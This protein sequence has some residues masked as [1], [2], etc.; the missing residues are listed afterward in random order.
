MEPVAPTD[1]TH[2]GSHHRKLRPAF[3]T[4]RGGTALEVLLPHDAELRLPIIMSAISVDGPNA[5]KHAGLLNCT[6][7]H[8]HAHHW[9][10]QCCCTPPARGASTLTLGHPRMRRVQSFSY[11]S[12]PSLRIIQ[13]TADRRGV[14]HPGGVPVTVVAT[15]WPMGA[16]TSPRDESAA[17]PR[18]RFGLH[19]PPVHALVMPPAVG[20][21]SK[22]APTRGANETWIRCKAPPMPDEANVPVFVAPNG[23]DWE[24]GGDL[25][26]HFAGVRPHPHHP[27]R[28][29]RYPHPH[30]PPHPHHLIHTT[31]QGHSATRFPRYPIPAL[32]DSRATQF[33][34]IPIPALPDSRATR[35][36]RTQPARIDPP[37][38]QI[39]EA[40]AA[41][42]GGVDA[43][44]VRLTSRGGS[45]SSAREHATPSTLPSGHADGSNDSRMVDGLL[46][47]AILL[48]IGARN[49]RHWALACD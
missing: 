24:G 32:P 45:A 47:L 36:L 34:R 31:H 14:F 9:E 23:V 26:V 16:F 29:Q 13:P 10:L 19:G 20:R 30:H 42:I 35:F 17:V 39:V 12:A 40:V 37:V 43:R 5:G 21:D 25:T 1:R 3:G 49:W 4:S 22:T 48:V 2:S 46:V 6:H 15:G 44:P 11:Y 27:P 28:T 8:A 18:C 7:G 33:R 41:S 38:A